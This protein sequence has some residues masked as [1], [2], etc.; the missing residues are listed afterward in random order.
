VSVLKEEFA[1][2]TF[3]VVFKDS[4]PFNLADLQTLIPV[5]ETLEQRL[6]RL[7][8]QKRV[9]LFMKGEPSGPQCGFSSKIVNLIEKY[10]KRDEYGYF[11]IFSD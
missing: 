6:E 4:K 5:K 9:V 10:L 2:E 8:N 3:P 1:L 7:I 11:D